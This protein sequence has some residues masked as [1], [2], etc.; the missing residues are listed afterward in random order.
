MIAFHR[1]LAST[2]LL[3]LLAATLAAGL[4]GACA[5]LKPA[6]PAAPA[7]TPRQAALQSQGFKRTARGWE[8]SLST[9]GGAEV[10]GRVT[11]GFDSDKLTDEGVRDISATASVLLSVGVSELSIEGHTDNQGAAAYNQALSERRAAAAAQ[12]FV[13]AGFK[14]A[15]IRRVGYGNARPID[16]NGTEAG[17]AQN[18]RVTIIV[19]AV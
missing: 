17:R 3:N 4:L 16:D 7:I 15:N 13:A 19:S 2:A 1:R 18:R 6:E 12:V 11:F 14:E 9:D 8:K 5:P 10:G